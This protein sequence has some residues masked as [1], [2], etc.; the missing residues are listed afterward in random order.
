MS[1]DYK[2]YLQDIDRAIQKIENYVAGV[3]KDAFKRN[4]MLID[5]VV[6]NLMTIGEAAKNI[7]DKVLSQLH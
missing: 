6:F 2:L 5:S 3:D 4:E 7:P 1:R